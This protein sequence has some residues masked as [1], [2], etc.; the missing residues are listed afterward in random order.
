METEEYYRKTPKPTGTC[1]RLL[2]LLLLSWAWCI[3]AHEQYE[4]LLD[5]G[6]FQSA[7]SVERKNKVKSE[8]MKSHISGKDGRTDHH[9]PPGHAIYA[10]NNRESRRDGQW[11]PNFVKHQQSTYH[12]NKNGTKQNSTQLPHNNWS[13]I[14]C[15]IN[16]RKTEVENRIRVLFFI[17]FVICSPKVSLLLL[18]L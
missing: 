9:H 1:F 8:I 14:N 13:G 17:N 5:S 16:I 4:L 6:R 7:V 11:I 2:P 18:L 12:A 15:N 10:E 3:W